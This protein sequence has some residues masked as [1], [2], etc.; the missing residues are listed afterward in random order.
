MK[1]PKVTLEGAQYDWLYDE[2]YGIAQHEEEQGDERVF[3]DNNMMVLDEPGI[4]RA[5]QDW[6]YGTLSYSVLLELIDF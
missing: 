3:D 5:I 4:W 6:L 2:F 1:S